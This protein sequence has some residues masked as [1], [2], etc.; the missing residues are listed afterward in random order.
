MARQVIERGLE[1][2]KPTM[3]ARCTGQAIGRRRGNN[4]RPGRWKQ[5]TNPGIIVKD[6]DAWFKP[7]GFH[8]PDGLGAFQRIEELEGER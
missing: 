1:G 2:L 7:A 5:G 8:D 6:M 3:K 4:H